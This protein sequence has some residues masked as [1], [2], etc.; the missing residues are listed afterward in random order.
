LT[1]TLNTGGAEPGEAD[2][3]ERLVAALP[4]EAASRVTHRVSRPTVTGPART[5]GLAVDAPIL[6][7][8]LAWHRNQEGLRPPTYLPSAAPNGLVAADHILM[9][10]AAGEVAHGYYYPTDYAELSHVPWGNRLDTVAE[11]LG[12]R[13]VGASGGSVV[14]RATA[15]ARV[16]RS[17]EEALVSGLNDAKLLDYFY[18]AERLRRWGTTAERSGIVSPLLVPEFIRAAFDLTPIQRTE[19]ALH[20]AVTARLVPEW[21][22]EPYYRAPARTVKPAWTPR[23]G[24]AVDRDGITSV[25]ANSAVWADGYD[26]TLV[27]QSWRSLLDGR[28]GPADERLLQRVIWRAVF[29]D[30]LDEVNDEEG[31]PRTPLNE[32]PSIPPPR[33]LVRGR[34]FAARG[35]RKL[36]RMVEPY[37]T[38]LLAFAIGGIIE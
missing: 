20:R 4:A 25:V 2:V 38:G 22:D 29:S 9:G 30:Y 34:R 28:G 17:L 23:L 27:A 16:R 6:P 13:L 10:G 1:V 24:H 14:A 7:N 35:L 26:T 11:S 5:F 8:V 31:T 37:N 12:E 32:S 3:A 15:I 33:P 18:A 36:A 21:K 19:N